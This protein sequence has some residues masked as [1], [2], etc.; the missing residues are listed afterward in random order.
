MSV[1]Y[2]PLAVVME[3]CLLVRNLLL[4][5][6]RATTATECFII[7]LH[8]GIDHHCWLVACF[9]TSSCKVYDTCIACI[10]MKKGG[11]RKEGRGGGERE[12]GKES[13][14]GECKERHKHRHV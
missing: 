2:S 11:R 4:A 6:Q 3:T 7:R 10:S 12:Q 1:A 8:R 14:E 5:L 9:N 13:T